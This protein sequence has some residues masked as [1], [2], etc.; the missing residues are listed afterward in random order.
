MGFNNSSG[1]LFKSFLRLFIVPVARRHHL[2][3]DE[4]QELSKKLGPELEGIKQL[5]RKGEVEML[6]LTKGEKVI[7]VGGG[8]VLLT[9]DEKLIPHL[10]A[11]HLTGLRRVVVDM[12]AVPHVTRGADI[13]APG[14]VSADGGIKPGA[15]VLIVDERHE[16]PLAIGLAMIQGRGMRGP[17]GKVVKNLHHVGDEAWC[18]S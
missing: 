1:C 8:P 16:K 3:K 18:L 2:R 6:E 14:V 15:T 17:R 10:S 13:M 9:S 5:L 11:V 12:G 4:I 7:L